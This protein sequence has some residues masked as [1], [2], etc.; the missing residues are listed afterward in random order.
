MKIKRNDFCLCG[1]GKKFKKCCVSIMQ[2]ETI[3]SH[4]VSE[5]TIRI[6][7]EVQEECDVALQ[8]LEA[9]E[10]LDAH[11]IVE[12]LTQSYPDYFMVKYVQ[13]LCCI[14]EKNEIDAILF[15]EEAV[16][17]FPIFSQGYFN[18]GILYK[19][20]LKISKSIACFKKVVQFE[21]ND[22]EIYKQADDILRFYENMIKKTAN[23]SLDIYLEASNLFDCAF[24]SLQKKKYEEAIVLFKQSLS[25]NPKTVQ[26]YNNMGLAYSKLGRHKMA[27][28]CFDKALVLDPSY[29]PAQYNRKNISQLTE[30]E[31]PETGSLDIDYYSDRIKMRNSERDTIEY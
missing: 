26:A 27:V 8:Y 13:G 19:N 20:T 31:I 30:G 12:R 28:E 14:F 17:L 6:I 25:L 23:I 1:S 16:K 24:E 7:P 5:F 11:D 21:N 15:L 18:L 29:E 3:Q 2:R 4:Q 9:G 10:I 22:S